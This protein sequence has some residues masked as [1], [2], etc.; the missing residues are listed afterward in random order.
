MGFDSRA[1]REGLARP[2]RLCVMISGGGRTLA[3]IHALI[4]DAE[5]DAKIELVIASRACTGIE[6]ARGLGY[7]PVT[8]GGRIPRARLGEL[9]AKHGIDW[10]VLAGYLQLLEIPEGFEGRVVNMHPALLPRFGGVGMYGDRVHAAVLA[11]GAKVSGCTV[12]LCDGEYDRGAM[13]LQRTCR[14]LA[15]DTV[16][17]LGARVFW[18]EREAYGAAL[19]LLVG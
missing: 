7:A 13:V 5:I 10:V 11:S 19:K 8:M 16:E 9:L 17:S 18:L 4:E 2:A 1:L 3:H 14:V 12:H 6:R 15:G